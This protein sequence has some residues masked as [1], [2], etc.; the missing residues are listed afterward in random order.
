MINICAETNS[1][2][3]LKK[4]LDI[5]FQQMFTQFDN[6][7]CVRSLILRENG[8]WVFWYV[9]VLL[10]LCALWFDK[11]WQNHSTFILARCLDLEA[12]CINELWADGRICTL[13]CK[14]RTKMQPNKTV[15]EHKLVYAH[16]GSLET[17]SWKQA[18]ILWEFWFF[19]LTSHVYTLHFW[20]ADGIL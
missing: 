15:R 19:F 9:C 5:I 12:S 13:T 18:I 11:Y 4:A 3:T 7:Q 6:A 2:N 10:Y 17:S 20:T 1:Y 16:F 14:Q 8:F